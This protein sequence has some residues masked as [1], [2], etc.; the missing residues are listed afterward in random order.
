MTQQA[1]QPAA[2]A[3]DFKLIGV[4]P[5]IF[6]GDK[7]KSEQFIHDF[8]MYRAFNFDHCIMQSPYLCTLL[9]LQYIKGPL[10]QD[11]ANDYVTEMNGSVNNPTNPVS[12]NADAHWNNFLANFRT[13]YTNTALLQTTYHQLQQLRMKDHNLDQ[14]VV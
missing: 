8:T 4:P 14:Y 11:W 7:T 3:A 12:E 6:D 2:A 9:A 13:V 10:V 1:A 5:A